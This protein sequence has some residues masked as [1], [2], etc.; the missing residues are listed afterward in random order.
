M[1]YTGP[2]SPA[3]HAERTAERWQQ[4]QADIKANA[5]LIL[6][7]RYQI[8]HPRRNRLTTDLA[9][10]AIHRRLTGS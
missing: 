10:E 4:L 1:P 5:P 7:A 2:V 6:T 8:A 3:S 9:V